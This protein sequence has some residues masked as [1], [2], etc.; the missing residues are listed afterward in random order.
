MRHPAS[1]LPPMRSVAD[2][3]ARRAWWRPPAGRLLLG[4]GAVVGIALAV[5][6]QAPGLILPETKLDLVVDP[7]GFLGRAT[8][9]WDGQ[10]A[11]GRVQNQA[12]GYLL[13]MGPFYAA[14]HALGVPG[15]VVQRTWI[16]LLLVLAGIGLY[17]LVRALGVGT[18]GSAAYATW[19][20]DWKATSPITAGERA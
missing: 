5:F 14:G 18:P 17:R 15:W 7:V 13:P 9:L 1:T 10:A 6:L 3:T 2:G 12:A 20:P 11:F 4:V 19:P 16:T 8:H